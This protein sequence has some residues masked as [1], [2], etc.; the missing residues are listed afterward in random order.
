MVLEFFKFSIEKVWKM[1]SKNVWEPCNFSCLVRKATIQNSHVVC[2]FGTA[3][4]VLITGWK[5]VAPLK[6]PWELLKLTSS[7]KLN[8]Q[9]E[10]HHS[11][12]AN[13]TWFIEANLWKPCL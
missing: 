5:R 6:A 2:A 3:E 7:M 10:S 9:R 13:H 12:T 4:H 8:Y 11:T 1:T